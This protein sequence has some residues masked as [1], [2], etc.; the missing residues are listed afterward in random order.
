[1]TSDVISQIEAMDSE[2][3]SKVVEVA[4]EG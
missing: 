3:Q 4:F 1:L 2:I